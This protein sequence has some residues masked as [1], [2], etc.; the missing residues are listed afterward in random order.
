MGHQIVSRYF[1]LT[2][3]LSSRV[4]QRNSNIGVSMCVR[5]FTALLNEALTHA[6]PGVDVRRGVFTV[7]HKSSITSLCFS[8]KGC[9]FL[10]CF[11]C[12]FFWERVVMSQYK[13]TVPHPPPLQLL[14]FKGILGCQAHH[15]AWKGLVVVVGEEWGRVFVIL[16]LSKWIGS[17]N[18][19]SIS[20]H[21]KIGL[22]TI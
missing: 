19:L 7:Q 14:S 16:A 5:V 2:F 15:S 17:M 11:V 1:G 4:L 13:T 20:D 10:F 9:G 3:P 21:R 18:T 12:L 22:E 8:G 6:N